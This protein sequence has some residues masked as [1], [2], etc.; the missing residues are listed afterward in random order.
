[1]KVPMVEGGG[2]LG[3]GGGREGGEWVVV[4]IGVLLN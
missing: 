1:M 2:S 4:E 3:E